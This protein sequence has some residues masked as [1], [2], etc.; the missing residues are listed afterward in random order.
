MAKPTGKLI[1][2]TP[3]S[4]GALPT[5]GTAV[6][7]AKLATAR[8]INGVAF[9]GTADINLT[10]ANIGALTDTQAA[11]KYA[12][13]S[14][15]VNGQPLSADVNLLAGDVNAWNKTEADGRYLLKTAT[16]VAATKLATARKIAGA[17]FDGTSDISLA[18]LGFNGL[19]SENGYQIFPGGMILQ[20]GMMNEN[21]AGTFPIPFPNKCFVINTTT[22]R[23]GA[24]WDG[25]VTTAFILDNRQF[26]AGC[27]QLTGDLMYWMAIGY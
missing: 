12:L 11:Q 10:P 4:I 23:N 1:R 3:E 25:S 14:I 5:G 20:W 6:A 22:R 24:P 26:T 18:D 21:S 13:R 9:D 19:I 7:A 16:A 15:R 8:K 2:T 27:G 17:T